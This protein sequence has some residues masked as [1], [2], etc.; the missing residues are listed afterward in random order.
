MGKAMNAG[1]LLKENHLI[2]TLYSLFTVL[3]SYFLY[4]VGRRMIKSHSKEQARKSDWL[5][6][7]VHMPS[8]CSNFLG[9]EWNNKNSGS[10]PLKKYSV[11]IF[12][13]N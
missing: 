8:L 12:F 10:L 2:E 1:L 6:V 13:R 3:T 9:C 4:P 5:P 11:V 7:S